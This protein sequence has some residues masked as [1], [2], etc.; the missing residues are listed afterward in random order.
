MPTPYKLGMLCA[1]GLLA[2]P[3]TA[4]ACGGTF[5]DGG[6]PSMAVE[7]T[8]ETILFVF[9]GQ[10]VE[11][12]V[13][14]EYDGGDASQFAWIV[15][16]PRV[17]E[18][19]VGSWR[20]IENSL[21][22]TVPVYGYSTTTTCNDSGGI[23]PSGPG[24]GFIQSPDGGAASG[25]D[26]PPN[27]VAHD[28]VGA[29]EYVVLD[30]GTPESVN[31][32]LT[33]EG[34]APNP[35]APNILAEYLDED[36]VF[37]AF[38]LRHFAGTDDIHPV[39]IRYEG[40]EPCVPL[41]LTRIAATEDMPI[42]VLFLGDERVLPT[43]YKHIQLNRAR[44]D[45]FGLGDNYE[46]LVTRAIDEGGSRGFVTEYA[47]PSDLIDRDNLRTKGLD[48]S[49]FETMEVTDVV[50]QLVA[51][52]LMECGRECT[53][54]HELA[55]SLLSEFVPVPDGF[56]ALEFYACLECYAEFIDMSAWDGAAFAQ[57]F[58]ERVLDPMDHAREVLDTWPHMTRLYT[59]I[60]PEE[61]LID[62]M[63]AEVAG[64]PD[65]PNRLGAQR[66][67]DC[68]GE[69]MALPGGR[70][71]RTSGAWPQWGADM[72]WAERV[73]QW[74]PVGPP[75]VE[76]NASEAI[77]AIVQAHNQTFGCADGETTGST[78][79]GVSAGDGTGTGPGGDDGTS[80]GTSAGGGSG[81]GGIEDA[82]GCGCRSGGAGAGWM[83]LV[84]GLIGWRKWS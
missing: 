11:A 81:G 40:N 17:P 66:E 64:L 79:D 6:N 49:V 31:D 3:R 48:A 46:Q 68:C 32:W 16:L 39:V 2:W 21:E 42:R 38:K 5:C 59:R 12:H 22:A 36:M 27:V 25:G 13:Q 37:I 9:D 69:S 78:S 34:Y 61:M 51:Y 73:E 77:D 83:L 29:F 56:E 50:D 47:G 28:T 71:I 33:E 26:P 43:N 14:I 1:L 72:P 4:E 57:A 63:F 15:P 30:G 58:Q 62:P 10:Y 8:G 23:D 53:Y 84:I 76:M 24:S 19:S 45:W 70:R 67:F 7:Q 80:G 82:Q 65:V 18:V 60:S 20:L 44:L 52:G 54:A 35:T 41:R 75:L 55:P 74:N